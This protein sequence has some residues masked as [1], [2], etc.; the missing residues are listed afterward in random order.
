MIGVQVELITN[1]DRNF[2]R[3]QLL[4]LY[5]AF[6]QACEVVSLLTTILEAPSKYLA[7]VAGKLL[8]RHDR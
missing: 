8:I 7:F 6:N 4:G 3:W 1:Q 2:R 5:P